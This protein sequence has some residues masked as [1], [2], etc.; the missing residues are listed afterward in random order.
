M[1]LRALTDHYSADRIDLACARAITV[2]KK[3]VVKVE[4]ILT[5]G[6]DRLADEPTEQPGTPK[7]T[8]N[9]RGASYFAS[10]L[11]EEQDDCDV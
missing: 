4:S 6:L 9:V 5:S 10:L 3:N 7:A 11:N 2:G 1:K 8:S